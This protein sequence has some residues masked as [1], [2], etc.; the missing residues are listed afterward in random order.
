MHWRGN[1]P[2]R[3][4]KARWLNAEANPMVEAG[5]VSWGVVGGL[6]YYKALACVLL[7]LIFSLAL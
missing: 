7:L 1:R 5:I 4:D 2:E 6:L 3:S